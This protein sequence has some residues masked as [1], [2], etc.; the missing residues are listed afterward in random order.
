MSMLCSGCGPLVTGGASR[1][2]QTA[3]IAE[4]KRRASKGPGGF[5]PARHPRIRWA[6]ADRIDSFVQDDGSDGFI[7]GSHPTPTG[8]DEFVDRVVPLQERG[9]LRADYTG[10][11]LR[12]NLGIPVTGP[13]VSATVA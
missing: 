6:V 12:D 10:T 13:A 8:L 1:P 2:R 5:I 4:A 3:D 11:T 7:I 9:S